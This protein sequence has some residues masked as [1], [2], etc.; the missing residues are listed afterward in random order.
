M[1]RGGRM[2]LMMMMMMMMRPCRLQ[3]RRIARARERIA[4]A[5]RSRRERKRASRAQ[6]GVGKE[7]ASQTQS[8]W[9]EKG[10]KGAERR[11][12]QGVKAMKEPRLTASCRGEQLAPYRA[13]GLELEEEVSSV[14]DREWPIELPPLYGSWHSPRASK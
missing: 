4:Q 5:Q 11:S 8:G 12:S 2:M 6:R 14:E 10:S 3:H 13:L 1:K 9:R 7:G